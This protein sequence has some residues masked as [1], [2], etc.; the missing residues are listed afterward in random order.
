MSKKSIPL[1]IG[2]MLLSNVM[3]QA[4][5]TFQFEGHTY[6]IT[7]SGATWSDADTAAQ[8]SFVD[9]EQ[10]YLAIIDSAAED[11]A[12]FNALISAGVSTVASDG[13]GAT[14]AWLGGSG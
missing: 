1:L 4:D 2:C 3:V 6:Q 10:G 9:G 14:Y 13:G 12:V 7:T 5:S 11:T 8:A